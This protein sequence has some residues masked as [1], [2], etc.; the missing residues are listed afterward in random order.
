MSKKS[1]TNEIN[2]IIDSSYT[3]ADYSSGN[4]YYDEVDS[5]RRRN[6]QNSGFGFGSGSSGGNPFSKIS[7]TPTPTPASAH[8]QTSHTSTPNM[9]MKYTGNNTN[10]AENGDK[11]VATPNHTE[12]KNIEDEFPSLGS[13]V[14]KKLIA[15]KTSAPM[16]FKKIVETKKPVEVMPQVVQTK[17]KHDDYYN[18]FK[19]YEEVKYYSEKTARS[20]IYSGAYSDDDDGN[21]D[22]Y[23]DD[24]DDD[25]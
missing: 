9:F 2:D 6:T 17:P 21:N 22:Y 3:E 18:R 24:D 23:D 10:N 19:I 11:S 12:I 15:P 7:V 1:K 5:H 8:G 4:A 25:E 16:N 20:K 13:S 14:N